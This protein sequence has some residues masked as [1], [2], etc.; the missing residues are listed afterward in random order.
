MP[1]WSVILCLD[2]SMSAAADPT[3]AE[4]YAN[5]CAGCH[6]E[7]LQTFFDREWKHGKRPADLANIIKNGYDADGMPAYDTTF[8]TAEISA[9]AA[10]ILESLEQTDRQFKVSAPPPTVLESAGM[11]LRIEKVW[12][13][14]DV[15]WGMAWLPNGDLL[16]TE[17]TG[18]LL[19]RNKDGKVSVISGLP[20]IRDRGQGGLLDLVLHPQYPQNG[21]LYF[22]F[23]KPNPDNSSQATTAVMRAQLKG[24]A[25]T[26]QELIFEALPYSN[27]SHH[28]GSRLV[29]DREGFL[30]ISVGDRGDHDHNPQNLDNHCG[31]IHRV[32]DDGSIPDDNPF[33]GMTGAIASI[34]SYGHRNPQGLAVHPVTGAL[35]ETEHGPRGGDEINLVQKGRN[36]GWPVISYGINYNGTI[37]TPNT[38]KEG[39]EQPLYYWNPSIG[40]CG[41]TFVKGDRYPGWK[42][43]LLSGSLRF[44]YIHRNQL[45]GDKVASHELLLQNIGRLRNIAQGPDGY[46]YFATETPGIIYR[47]MPEG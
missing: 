42:H 30:F 11:Q 21:W 15:P 4:N 38:A 9:L 6:G 31:K 32:R 12:E 13:G 41:L 33:V 34:F 20:D 19:R 16:I 23:S 5:Y 39:M 25:L 47:I 27:R 24:D 18:K 8:T 2:L 44:K 46:V 10:F 28:F 17:R 45:E 7:H 40:A 35:W 3:P 43:N 26:N 1:L 37:L 22:S 29:F 14:L 36:Y